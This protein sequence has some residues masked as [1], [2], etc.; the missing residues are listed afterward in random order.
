MMIHHDLEI[1]VLISADEEWNFIRDYL[2]PLEVLCSPFGEWFQNSMDIQHGHI[3]AAFFQ[4][5]CGKMPA[6]AA[7]Q[8]VID[9]YN[10]KLIINLGTCGGFKGKVTKKD[11]LLVKE[12]VIYDICERSGQQDEMIGRYRCILD[13]SW[14]EEPYPL[15]VIPA[16]MATADQDLDVEMIPY[17]HNEYGA[18]AADWEAGA[19]AYVGHKRNKKK[20]LILKGVSDFGDEIY[21]D[22]E[23]FKK[24]VREIMPELLATL[25]E[26]ISKARLDDH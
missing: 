7:T 21:E 2:D 10:P 3:D 17:L 13:L 16:I 12:T 18:V 25:P 8:F 26:W 6:A 15:K 9:K 4:T 19:I 5:G 14:L 11:I 23:E 22:P 20:C 1:I 24:R